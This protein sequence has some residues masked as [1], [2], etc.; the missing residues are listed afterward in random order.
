MHENNFRMAR[1]EHAWNQEEL[2]RKLGVSQTLV[3]LWE[4]GKR[5]LPEKRVAQLRRLGVKLDPALLPLREFPPRLDFAQEL[6][7]LGYPAFAHFANGEPELNPAQF[8]ILALAQDYLERRT[9]EGL[10]W[11]V[12]RYSKMDWE[13]VKREAK[14]RDLQNRLGFTLS[15]AKKLAFEQDQLKPAR[16]LKRQEQQLRNSLLAKEDTY[17]NERMTASE[18][19]WLKTNRSEEAAAWN[20][21]SDLA[22]GYVSYD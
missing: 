3:S 18:R 7:N 2:A 12:L 6:A 20:V 8:L 16:T 15:V 14:L 19:Q 17:C 11:V 13:W 9:A 10:P 22:P 1:K 4:R 5:R 21:L